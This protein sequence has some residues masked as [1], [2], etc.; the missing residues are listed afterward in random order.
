[1]TKI[2]RH[3]LFVFF[4]L[5][6]LSIQAQEWAKSLNKQ[7]L[8]FKEVKTA[9]NN[10]YKNVNAKDLAEDDEYSKYK[11]W[12]W[13]WE[14]RVSQTG[15]FPKSTILWEEWAKYVKEHSRMMANMAST[16][17]NW[18]SVGP[19]TTPG[20]YTG[21][22]RV[23]C[24][25]FHPTNPNTF[26]VG[27]PAGGIWKTTDG[28]LTWNTNTNVDHMP[29][30]G[31]SDIAV[32]PNT[33]NTMYIATGDGDLGSLWSIQNNYAGDTKTVGILKSTDG[34]ASFNPTGFSF[35]VTSS[36]EVKRVVIIPTATKTLLAASSSGIY[37]STDA[38]TSWQHTMSGYFID[39]QLCPGSPGIVYATTYGSGAQVFMSTDTAKTFTQVS[40]F[41]GISR[42][43]LAVSPAAPNLVEALCSN[44]T[45]HGFGGIYASRDFGA[46]FSTLYASGALN[47]LNGN[48]DGSGTT[49]Q[50]SYDLAFAISPVD[51]S[52]LF[53]GGVNTWKSSDAGHNWLLNT[54][55]TDGA[56]QNPDGVVTVH[57]D[58]HCIAFHPLST[59]TM[60]QTNDGG[61][62]KSTDGG[63]TYND[64]SNGLQ[65]SEMYRIACSQSDPTIMLAGLQDNGSRKLSGSTWSYATGGDGTTCAIDPAN[66]LNMVASYV[67]GQFYTSTDGFATSITASDNVPGKPTG[68]WVT[69]VVLNPVKA[70]T[71]Y[72][73]YSDV[74]ASSDWGA[75]WTAISTN[76][77]ASATNTLNFMAVAPSDTLTIYAATF[78][79]I[80][81]TTDGG[82]NWNSISQFSLGNSK[83]AI[84]IDPLHANHVWITLSG[85]VDGEK[86]YRTIDGGANWTNVS[87]TLPNIPVNSVVYEKGSNDGVY[88]GTDVGVY[89][90][91]GTLSD[92]ILFST[93]LPNVVVTDLQI[94]Y[95]SGKLRAATFGRG[96]WESDLYTLVNAI[97]P[98]AKPVS[99]AQIYPNPNKGSFTISL[100][101]FN[102]HD[103][104]ILYNYL[105]E[106][107]QVI[108]IHSIR[109]SVDISRLADGIYYV[110]LESE[111]FTNMHKVIKL[112]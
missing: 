51:T 93:G 100:T 5:C 38:G 98:I 79:S 105:G 12:E 35:S 6:T 101:D 14:P 87:G 21:L 67:Q 96:L 92:W 90:T 55:W 64:L 83:T 70:V 3:L 49:G 89:Y 37:R 8:N 10:Y 17:G 19:A 68:S 4:V 109:Q 48:F 53:V 54:M 36:Q 91:N 81:V 62:Y 97:K 102:G 2:R 27:T 9:F 41:I 13:Y 76:L 104:A 28:G 88:I 103:K 24:I 69:P 59:G 106:T 94:Q 77:T 31:V 80:Y 22:G 75:S 34:G 11:R 111:H 110:G 50:G 63:T 20:G 72:A 44:E 42:I 82:A 107:I 52:I 45:G 108:D 30:L 32:D 56:S 85:Y 95:S 84:A 1:M 60:Y 86:V 73:G 29:V 74:Y 15:E 40:N 112:N 18:S 16:S 99:G 71:M 58:K 33:P 7:H 47:M 65:I 26:W 43:A 23:S 61:I 57:A 25:G 66:P 46:T 78:D 39:L